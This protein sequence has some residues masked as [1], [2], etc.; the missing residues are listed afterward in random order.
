MTN[1]KEKV[2]SCIDDLFRHMNENDNVKERLEK[3]MNEIDYSK[4]EARKHLQSKDTLTLDQ[5]L[6]CLEYTFYELFPN[7]AL[8]M[9]EEYYE[10]FP[11]QIRAVKEW[12]K[13]SK[14][15]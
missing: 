3:R 15:L 14:L 6:G 8:I 1:N 4:G 11:D 10:Q 9:E 5:F 7:K 13:D 2:F 12:Y